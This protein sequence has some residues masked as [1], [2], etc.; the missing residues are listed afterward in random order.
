MPIADFTIASAKK[1][2]KIVGSFEYNDYSPD[3]MM[4]SPEGSAVQRYRIMMRRKKRRRQR[5][6]IRAGLVALVVAA[7]FFWWYRVGS[8][9]ESANGEDDVNSLEEDVARS[10]VEEVDAVESSIHLIDEAVED[11]EQPSTDIDEGEEMEEVIEADVVDA[12]SID[13][14]SPA[15]DVLNGDEKDEEDSFSL[16]SAFAREK[17]QLVNTNQ[18]PIVKLF[19]AAKAGISSVEPRAVPFSYFWNKEVWDTAK[20]KPVLSGIDELLDSMLQ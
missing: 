16:A 10:L 11:A 12:P 19:K 13:G 1:S 7:I 15:E 5:R 20:S 6:M 8:G 17:I 14:T 3:I 4:A 18:A 9:E 2:E